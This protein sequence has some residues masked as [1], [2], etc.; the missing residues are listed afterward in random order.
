MF[1]LLSVKPEFA[2][3]ILSGNKKYEFRRTIFKRSA[4]STVVL[5]SNSTEKKIVG[6]FQVG[7]IHKGTP[8]EI[9]KLCSRFAGIGELDFFDY[10]EGSSCAYAI[11]IRNP[12]KFTPAI[13]PR[14]VFDDFV[15]PQSFYY[16]RPRELNLLLEASAS[17]QAR[18]RDVAGVPS[19]YATCRQSTLA[20]SR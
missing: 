20:A 12:T 16:L 18:A 11:A 10:F 6:Y 8:R 19:R 15:P 9:W 7:R 2:S 1:V 17:A 13:D 14:S 5:Y 3:A 4:V